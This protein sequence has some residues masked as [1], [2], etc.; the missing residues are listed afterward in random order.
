MGIIV[1]YAVEV[2][3][4]EGIPVPAVEVGARYRY[5]SSPRTWSSELTDGDG[6]AHFNDEHPEPPL[7][8]C[9]FVGDSDCGSQVVENG[10]RYILEM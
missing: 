9:L 3:D 2:V 4:G 8:V 6:C 7:E 5:E 10:A 1:P